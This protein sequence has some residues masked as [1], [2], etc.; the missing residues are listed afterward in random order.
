MPP[1]FA[2]NH[3]SH[4]QSCQY[5]F[6]NIVKKSLQYCQEKFTK[7]N[8]FQAR[9]IRASLYICFF[10]SLILYLYRA[11]ILGQKFFVTLCLA[12]A[13]LVLKRSASLGPLCAPGYLLSY[14][15][16]LTLFLSW[17]GPMIQSIKRCG[18]EKKRERERSQGLAAACGG[19]GYAHARQGGRD[20]A[21]P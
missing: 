13:L 3:I 6:Y 19:R 16:A 4:L 18:T 7:K 9:Y 14:P 1:L 5:L 15:K 10:I 21:D 11:H 12:G 17:W 20:T 8:S 2:L